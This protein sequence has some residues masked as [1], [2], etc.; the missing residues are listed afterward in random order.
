[1][2]RFS[3]FIVIFCLLTSLFSCSEHNDE[4][5]EGG[6][7]IWDIF[8][9]GVNIRIVDEDGNNLLNPENEGN[10]VGE[11]MMMVYK[12]EIYPAKWTY[13]EYM[14]DTKAIW[15]NFY[16]LVWSGIFPDVNPEGACLSF[17]Q[18]SGE[19]NHNISLTFMIECINTVFE[20]KFTHELEWINNQPH[21]INYITYK[22]KRIEGK[23]LE[24][25][26]PKKTTSE[27]D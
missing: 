27:S 17:G 11:K 16:G 8:P 7:V 13:E 10:W 12:D 24:L 19:S 1:M 9:T 18:F 20:F 4:P 2:K 22:G 26:L 23:V 6:T 21:S 25:V 5:D 3:N 15:V 14:P